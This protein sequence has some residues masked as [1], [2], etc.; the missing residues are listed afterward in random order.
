MEL[1]GA[2]LC[3]AQVQLD[4]PTEAELLQTVFRKQVYKLS[5]SSSIRVLF[6]GGRLPSTRADPQ[7]LQRKFT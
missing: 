5:R 1:A 2:E 6:N 3:Q 4:S 7:M